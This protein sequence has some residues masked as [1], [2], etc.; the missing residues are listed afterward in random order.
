MTFYVGSVFFIII[1][2]GKELP[3]P[4][5]AFLSSSAVK[6]TSNNG[7]NL[8]SQPLAPAL[9]DTVFDFVSPLMDLFSVF[10]HAK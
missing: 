5:Q 4:W 6:F 10:K 3:K 2:C 8:F 9:A 1:S 7:H